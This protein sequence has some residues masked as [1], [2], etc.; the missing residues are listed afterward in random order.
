MRVTAKATIVM[1][2][3]IAVLLIHLHLVRCRA[4]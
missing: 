2:F 4:L 1:S 3:V